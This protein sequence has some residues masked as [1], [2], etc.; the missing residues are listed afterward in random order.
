MIPYQVHQLL[1][2]FQQGRSNFDEVSLKHADLQAQRLPF[3]SFKRAKLLEANFRHAILP[4]V[5]LNAAIL[6][7]ANF[8]HANLLAS[9]LSWATLIRANLSHALLAC[10]D[11]S[12]ADLTGANLSGAS[13]SNAS[14]CSANLRN[15]NLAGA[16]LKGTDLSRAILFGARL[17]PHAL[18][19]AILNFTVMPNG[20]CNTNEKATQKTPISL[21]GVMS[22]SRLARSLNKQRSRQLQSVVSAAKP[23]K[24]SAKLIE[25]DNIAFVSEKADGTQNVTFHFSEKS[26]DLDLSVINPEAG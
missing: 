11:L 20:D 12:G 18:K 2:A 9:D 13:L 1:T 10:S 17:D 19:D 23:A 3:V 22:Y 25:P 6:E 26:G 7:Q 21:S 8:E 24:I 16:N 4:G 15:A 5:I 14:L